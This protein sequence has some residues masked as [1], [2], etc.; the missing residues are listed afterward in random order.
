MSRNYLNLVQVALRIEKPVTICGEMAHEEKYLSFLLG[1]S[2]RCFSIDPRFLPSLQAKIR[3]L[4][5]SECV[6]FSRNL[7]S[8]ASLRGIEELMND[9]EHHLAEAS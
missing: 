4:D 3:Q 1:I 9:F 8:E 5:M 6:Q 2:I 7:L